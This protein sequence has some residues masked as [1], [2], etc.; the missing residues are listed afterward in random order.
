MQN[1]FVSHF[2]NKEKEKAFHYLYKK[3]VITL[4]YFAPKIH[5]RSNDYF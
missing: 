4:R 1:S 5:K 3:Y 2:T